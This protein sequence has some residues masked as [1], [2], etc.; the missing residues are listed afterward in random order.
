[1][2][3][4]RPPHPRAALLQGDGYDRV[5]QA[6]SSAPR[7]GVRARAPSVLPAVPDCDEKRCRTGR[8]TVSS[9]VLYDDQATQFDERAGIPVHAAEAVAR[10][11]VAVT[12]LGNGDLL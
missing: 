9:P 8:R 2:Q 11:V 1:M 7:P 10:E 12:G 3:G 6:A 4:W 5:H